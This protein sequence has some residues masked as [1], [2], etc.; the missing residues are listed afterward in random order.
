[1]DNF[2]NQSDNPLAED[3]I[4]NPEAVSQDYIPQSEC[5]SVETIAP[6]EMRFEM[7][8]AMEILN[9]RVGGVDKYV[10]EKLGYINQ[11][12]L[13]VMEIAVRG[14]MGIQSGENPRVIKQ[15]LTT[16]IPPRLRTEVEEAA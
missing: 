5:K 8:K 3:N 10:A 4:Q 1:M 7:L 14:I 15:K 6:K 16:F 11:R 9:Q 13:L 2:V 12:E